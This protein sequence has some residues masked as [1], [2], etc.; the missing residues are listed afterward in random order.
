MYADYAAAARAMVHTKT[1]YTPIPEES[2]VY[3]AKF[4]NYIRMWGH[5]QTYYTETGVKGETHP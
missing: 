3:A 4:Q 1:V 5:I 2:A